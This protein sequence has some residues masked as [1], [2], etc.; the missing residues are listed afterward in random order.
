MES[1]GQGYGK[2]ILFGEHFVVYGL[3]AIASAIGSVTEARVTDSDVYELVDNRPATPTYKAEKFDEQVESNNLIFRFCG[4]DVTEK[5]F[6]LE[7]GGDLI[8]ASGVGASAASA[9]AIARALNSRFSLGFDIEKINEAAYEGEK[10]YHGKP[11]GLDNTVSVYGGLIWFVKNLE[12]GSN[13]FENIKMPEPV[14]IVLG[15]TGLTASTK[16]VVGDVRQEKEGN[17]E[18]FAEIFKEYGEIVNSARDVLISG[19]LKKV[20]ELMN[21]N[22]SLLQ[23]ITVSCDQ[24]DEIV[25]I[26]RDSGALGSKLTGTGRGGLVQALTPGKELQDAVAAAIEDA[27]YAAYKTTIGV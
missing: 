17:P 27:G 15:N 4:V 19:D 20:G 8:A 5:P 2:T 14:E 9:T 10:G 3:P 26:A 25:G 16:K 22:H 23:E 18:K 12:G 1:V 21:R 7:L 13:T 6:K 24:S 11:S